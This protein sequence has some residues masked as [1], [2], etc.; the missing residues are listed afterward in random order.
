[1]GAE[2]W[3]VGADPTGSSDSWEPSRGCCHGNG[4]GPVAP[5]CLSQALSA[6]GLSQPPLPPRDTWGS[7]ELPAHSTLQGKGSSGTSFS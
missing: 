5:S 3:E 1:M 2:A 7:S 6:L 4:A